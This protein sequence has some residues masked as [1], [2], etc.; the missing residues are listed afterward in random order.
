MIERDEHGH[1]K[2]INEV[3][4]EEVTERTGWAVFTG[5]EG[6]T[7]HFHAFF[8]SREDAYAY[9]TSRECTDH[10]SDRYLCDPGVAP[11]VLADGSI[12]AANHYDDVKGARACA[13]AID[14]RSDLAADFVAEAQEDV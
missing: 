14:L 5:C 12:I 6:E 1:P 11:A 10:D 13:Q 3:D 9:I 7:A 2:S 8:A 4:L